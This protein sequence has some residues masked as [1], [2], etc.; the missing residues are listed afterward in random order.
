M[1]AMHVIHENSK[2]N[3]Y[4]YVPQNLAVQAWKLL[5]YS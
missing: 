2:F 1:V 5:N 4:S 3:Y